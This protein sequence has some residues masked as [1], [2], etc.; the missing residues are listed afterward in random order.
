MFRKIK[1]LFDKPSKKSSLVLETTSIESMYHVTN[2]LSGMKR[3]II[4]RLCTLM[5]NDI[6]NIR[7]IVGLCNEHFIWK[8]HLFFLRNRPKKVAMLIEHNPFGKYTLSG[9]PPKLRI[10]FTGLL[11]TFFL[12]SV[13][14]MGIFNWV[15]RINYEGKKDC[16]F[17]IGAAPPDCRSFCYN[18]PR[19]NGTCSFCFW[20][21]SY[22]QEGKSELC[23]VKKC[24]EIPS[25]ETAVPDSSLV[26]IEADCGEKTLSFFVNHRKIPRVISSVRNPLR[27]GMSGFEE[28]HITCVSFLRYTAPTRSSVRCKYHGLIDKE[29][30]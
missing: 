3:D 15:V 14:T 19:P 29:D 10:L 24:T 22:Y 2:G 30:W 5:W 21:S 8:K 27:F 1:G 4:F 17:H 6:E 12:K 23:G 25:N 28:G 18:P 26:E 11:G 16:K 7:M 13:I 9:T 20:I